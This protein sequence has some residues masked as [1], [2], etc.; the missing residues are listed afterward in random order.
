MNVQEL[1][2]REME[3]SGASE[4]SEDVIFYLG[5][6]REALESEPSLEECEEIR[7]KIWVW[8]EK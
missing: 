7:K 3:K 5:L 1:I 4:Y 8:L 2:E 6:S